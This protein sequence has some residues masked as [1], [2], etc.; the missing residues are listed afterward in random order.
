MTRGRYS[1]ARWP[2]ACWNISTTSVWSRSGRWTW[3]PA[4]GTRSR[5]CKDASV[6]PWRSTGKQG[7]ES[8]DPRVAVGPSVSSACVR[9]RAQ[10]RNARTCDTFRARKSR[11]ALP[12]REWIPWTRAFAFFQCLLNLVLRLIVCCALRSAADDNR[13]TNPL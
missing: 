5:S 8:D 6:R 3:R 13:R 1:S 7:S 4:P 2:T 12:I 10:R 11:L 9:G